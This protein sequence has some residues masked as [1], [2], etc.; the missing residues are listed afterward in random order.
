M[1]EQQGTLYNARQLQYGKKGP[2]P[3][4]EAGAVLT[5]GGW[6]QPAFPV[7]SAAPLAVRPCVLGFS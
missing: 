1:G 2:D 4:D 3:W 5:S 6:E 7:A